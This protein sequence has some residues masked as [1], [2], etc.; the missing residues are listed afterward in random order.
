MTKKEKGI[1]S[2]DRSAQASLFVSVSVGLLLVLPD[3]ANVKVGMTGSI[4]IWQ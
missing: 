3:A 2:E 1:R 4:L